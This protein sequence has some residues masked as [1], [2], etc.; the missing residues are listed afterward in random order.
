MRAY[1]SE[2]LLA[3]A[4]MRDGN[5]AGALAHVNAVRAASGLDPLATLDMDGLMFEREKELFAEGF[6]KRDQELVYRK[7]GGSKKRARASDPEVIAATE[8]LEIFRF[9]SSDAGWQY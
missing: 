6:R 3:E 7:S 4:E 9:D 8:V 1:E 2:G 5:A